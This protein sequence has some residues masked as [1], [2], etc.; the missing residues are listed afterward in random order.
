MV[1]EISLYKIY[2][3]KRIHEIYQL[4]YAYVRKFEKELIV[5]NKRKVMRNLIIGTIALLTTLEGYSQTTLSLE[6]CK[7]LAL[8]N[9]VKTTSCSLELEAAKEMKK[10]AYTNYFPKV[11]ANL[12]GMYAIDPLIKLNIP[13]ANLPVYDGNPAT[14]PTATQFAYFPGMGI[15]A[16]TRSA[17]GVVNIAQPI[18]VGGKIK[19]GNQL[20]QLN[21]EVKEQQQQLSEKEVVLQTEQQYWQLLSLQERKKT[22]EKYELLLDGVSK[23]VNDAFLS[24]LIIKNDVLKVQIK[25]SELESNKR[26]LENGRKLALMQFCNTIGIPYDS[27]LVL[28]DVIKLQESPYQY[29]VNNEEALPNRPEYQLLEKSVGAAQLQTKMKQG[30]LL[31][32]VALG[33]SGYHFNMLEK[34]VKGTTNGMVY[35]TVSIPISDWWGGIHNV[36]EQ[37]IREQIAV[38][39]FNDAKVLLALQMEKS[40]VDLIESYNQIALLQGIVVQAEENVK[41]SETGYKSGVVT[42]SDLLEAQALLVE[43]TN[44]LIETQMHYQLAITMYLQ[45]TGR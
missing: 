44:N 26:K 34:G 33:L 37:K 23:Q 24:G 21:L 6:E 27:T 16:L 5:R 7:S 15:N 36:N 39:N 12:M 19:T 4:G 2:Y 8:K 45:L 3:S 14:I 29:L 41:V 13:S 42:V 10:S 38:A 25:Q 17:V 1:S 20:A 31:P 35:A 28:S 40:R 43:T 32:T 22:L 30:E 11:S 18:Y 9:N